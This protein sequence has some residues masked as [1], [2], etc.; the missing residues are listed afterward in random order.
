MKSHCYCTWNA[1][2]LHV[3]DGKPSSQCGLLPPMA[4]SS[5][6]LLKVNCKPNDEMNIGIF[7]FDAETFSC[8]HLC[9]GSFGWG[10]VGGQGV[11]MH[12]CQM[13]FDLQTRQYF[14]HICKPTHL[15]YSYPTPDSSNKE[16]ILPCTKLSD[17]VQGKLASDVVKISWLL[18]C[19]RIFISRDY[20]VPW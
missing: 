2:L 8:F 1:R 19:G 16:V 17:D 14:W 5:P 3:D 13:S 15:I 10:I 7:S 4:I 20:I 18:F 6:H 9:R 12:T 11:Y